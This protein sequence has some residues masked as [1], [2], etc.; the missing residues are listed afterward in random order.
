MSKPV[1]M[2]VVLGLVLS[3]CGGG[4]ASPKRP[5]THKTALTVLPAPRELIAAASPQANGSLWT[6][7][8]SS[9]VKTLSHIDLSD[10]KVIKSVGVSSSASSIAQST[11]GVLALGLGTS[12]TGAVEL[13]NA[14]T[15]VLENSLAVGAPVVALAFGNDGVT[16]YVLD[17][18][19]NSTSVTVVNTTSD[20]ILTSFGE[21]HDAIGL[22]PDPSQS[23]IWTIDR[24]GVVE[25]TS[26]A[27]G[28]PI[29]EFPV[30]D[31]G[32][33]IAMSPS[34][35]WLYVLKSMPQGSNVAVIVTSTESITKV[36]P[37]AANSIALAISQD[38]RTLYDFVGTANYGNIQKIPLG[39][40]GA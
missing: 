8:G 30:R 35:G 31:P 17:A 24:S 1:A 2:L 9:K 26:L 7:S 34:G 28:K 20:K 29:A 32:L 36:L 33:A 19:A 40:N 10:G 14:T 4:S 6:L 12:T 23:S 38:G 18:N 37:A 27:S 39:S 16:L 5:G 25:Q 13:L 21:P 11:T 22:I 15:G 3:A